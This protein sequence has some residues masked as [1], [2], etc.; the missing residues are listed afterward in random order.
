[1]GAGKAPAL[2]NLIFGAANVARAILGSLRERVPK[3]LVQRLVHINGE[4]GFV[5][6]LNGKPFAT[7]VMHASDGLVR[8][9]YIVTNLEKLCRMPH[10]LVDRRCHKMR[11]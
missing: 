6:Y 5:S 9:V 4:P 1:V 2:P 8:S 7:F 3:N 10:R 11:A